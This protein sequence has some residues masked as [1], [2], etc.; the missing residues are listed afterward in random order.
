MK[1]TVGSKNQTKLAAVKEAIALYPALFPD[2]RVEGVDIT[3]PEFGHP[4]SIEETMRGAQERAKAAFRDC[5]YSFGLEG[6]LIK[7][8]GSRTGFMET[9]FCVIYDGK[10]F[11]YGLGPSFEWPK[12]VTEVILSGKGDASAAFKQLGLTSHEK[13]GAVAGGNLGALTKGRVP[14][15]EQVKQS[16]MMALIQLEHPALY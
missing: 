9:N 12:K 6:G 2:A 4:K 5:D 11:Y 7:V 10:Q 13:Q 8:P 1:I 15:E 16:I 3:I 14:R